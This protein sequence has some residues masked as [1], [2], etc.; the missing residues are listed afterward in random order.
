[1]DYDLPYSFLGKLV[2]KLRV[3]RDL[4]KGTEKALKKLKDISEKSM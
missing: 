1:M 4:E 3:S 2:D